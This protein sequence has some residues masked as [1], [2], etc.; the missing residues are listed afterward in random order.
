MRAPRADDRSLYLGNTQLYHFVAEA[1]RQMPSTSD[2]VSSRRGHAVDGF[3]DQSRPCARQT[4]MSVRSSAQTA[5]DRSIAR[6]FERHETAPT[7][8]L[9][10]PPKT[11]PFDYEEVAPSFLASN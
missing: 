7:A 3:H 2:A 11:T 9:A 6:L 5:K 10:V 1:A 8:L 4:S